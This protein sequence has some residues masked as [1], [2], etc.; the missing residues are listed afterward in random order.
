VTQGTGGFP[1]RCRQGIAGGFE[2]HESA[3]SAAPADIAGFA[4]STTP[5]GGLICGATSPRRTHL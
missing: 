5:F 2:V 3:G 4:G 1:D